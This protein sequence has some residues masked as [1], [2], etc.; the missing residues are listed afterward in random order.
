[1]RLIA[2][3]DVKNENLI[4]TVCLEGLRKIGNPNEFA[5]KYVAQGADELLFMDLVASL[6]GRNNLFE[7]IHNITK[8]IFIP[9]TVGG[10]VRSVSDA[11]KLLENGA[12]KVLLNSSTFSNKELISNLANQ[13]GSSSVVLSIEAKKING[14]WY[15]FY[16]SGRENSKVTVNE[17]IKEGITKGAGEICITSVDREGTEKGF[18]LELLKKIKLLNI[19]KPLIIS[20]GISSKED[21]LEIQKIVDCSAVCVAS[22]L[23]YNKK[24]VNDL[25]I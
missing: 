6:Y 16:N 1:M 25:R 2:R 5:R 17:W 22:V 19:K 23:H 11:T 3:L 20:G 24:K 18:D 8:D 7:I 9:I 14:D 15:A 10:G 21:I 4:K 13:I 12:D